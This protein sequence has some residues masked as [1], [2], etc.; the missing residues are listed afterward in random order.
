MRR[1][2]EFYASIKIEVQGGTWNQVDISKLVTPA[3]WVWLTYA[4][5]DCY[6]AATKAIKYDMMIQLAVLNGFGIKNYGELAGLGAS[7]NAPASYITINPYKPWEGELQ[8][9][10]EGTTDLTV[11]VQDAAPAAGDTLN[12]VLGFNTQ[13]NYQDKPQVVEFA[14][15]L[16]IRDER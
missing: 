4:S 10:S 2:T 15:P 7:F 9:R 12:L 3:P 8:M 11:F 14:K 6:N 13:W 1:E 5:F 16:I